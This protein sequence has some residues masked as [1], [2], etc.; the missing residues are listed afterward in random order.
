MAK[1]RRCRSCGYV[2]LFKTVLL[3]GPLFPLLAFTK[4]AAMN[5]M[6]QGNGSDNLRELSSVSFPRQACRG[7]LSAG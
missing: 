6:A 4:Q 1:M 7:E 3:T 5:S 2:A